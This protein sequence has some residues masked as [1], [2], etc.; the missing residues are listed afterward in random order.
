MVGRMLG[1]I[2]IMIITISVCNINHLSGTLRQE[3]IQCDQGL[4]SSW[5]LQQI[6]L[7][8]HSSRPLF[9]TREPPLTF[10]FHHDLWR[11]SVPYKTVNIWATPS[12]VEQC[13]V[14]R[15][16][17]PHPHTSEHELP[18]LNRSLL[19]L[20]SCY[21]TFVWIVCHWLTA[22]H[23][24]MILR[25]WRRFSATSATVTNDALFLLKTNHSNVPKI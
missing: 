4:L 23:R 22:G 10:R 17:I 12:A 8:S 2:I 14:Q 1:Y 9:V 25:S 13:A 3:C 11:T 15:H 5:D 21:S 19:P 24:V 6:S 7:H 20:H 18:F 16:N